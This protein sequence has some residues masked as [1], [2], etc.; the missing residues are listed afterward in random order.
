MRR[1]RGIDISLMPEEI[2]DQIAEVNRYL[3]SVDELVTSN[4]IQPSSG[5]PKSWQKPYAN[6]GP[7]YA[8]TVDLEQVSIQSSQAIDAGVSVGDL[9]YFDGTDWKQTDA[10]AEA[11]CSKML[12]VSLGSRRVRVSGDWATT[13]LTAGDIYYASTTPGAIT[14]VMPDGSGDIVRIIGYALSTT[15]LFFNPDTTY[16]EVA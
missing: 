3:K 7:D 16:I 12:G 15:Q 2:R 6:P 4:L 11:T 10:D 1:F 9:V 13:G 14:N 8:K 5:S